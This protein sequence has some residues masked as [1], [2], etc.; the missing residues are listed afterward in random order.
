MRNSGFTIKDHVLEIS[1]PNRDKN[2]DRIDVSSA[3]NELETNIKEYFGG[4]SRRTEDG[5]WR[6][7]SGRDIVERN[8]I[9]SVGFDKTQLPEVVGT[10]LRFAVVAAEALNQEAVAIRVDGKLIIVSMSKSDAA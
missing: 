7:G 6:A 10:I 9:L 4:V 5:I 8:I 2:G 1:I 3:V